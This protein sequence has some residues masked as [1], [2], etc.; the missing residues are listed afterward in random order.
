MPR[1]TRLVLLTV[2]AL[3]L[4]P[5]T[6]VRETPPEPDFVSPVLIGK[7]QTR[8]LRTGPL[9]LESAW[10]LTSGND[11]F[12]G[13]SA[14]L[15][16]DG[17]NFLA[18]SDAG[19]LMYLPRPDRSAQMPTLDR[20]LDN[21]RIDKRRTDIESLTDDPQTGT[22]WAGL[23]QFNAIYRFSPDLVKQRQ[24]RPKAMQEW[25]P[26]SGA[27]AFVRLKDGRFLIIAEE[28]LGGGLHEALL[29][30]RDPTRG[31]EPARL[32]FRGAKGFNPADATLLPDGRML[33]VLRKVVLGWPLRFAVRLVVADPAEIEAGEVLESTRLAD[34]V[35]PLPTDNY[36]GAAVTV[37]PNGDWA[38]WL[39]SD[40]NFAKFQRTLLLKLI[41]PQAR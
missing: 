29:F 6:F 10:V 14:L 11:H 18:A 28:S 16:Q 33:V 7:L 3:A 37:E 20:F 13:Y 4:A 26:N 24:V 23:E 22:V 1:I 2:T 27:E 36:E 38:L 34:I 41:W 25:A 8:P 12:G 30:D 21:G 35:E 15:E 39:I 17:D 9:T 40:D 32:Q 31:G 5:G 19:R